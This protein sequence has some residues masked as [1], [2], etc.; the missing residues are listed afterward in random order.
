MGRRKIIR[1]PEEIVENE[2]T[3]KQR[4]AEYQK[5]Y[6]ERKKE[7]K[8]NAKTKEKTA[9]DIQPSNLSVFETSVVS[10]IC[11]ASTS[12]NVNNLIPSKSISPTVIKH[13]YSAPSIMK[14]GITSCTLKNSTTLQNVK[15]KQSQS[16]ASSINTENEHSNSCLSVSSQTNSQITSNNAH[17]VRFASLDRQNYFDTNLNPSTSR[18]VSQNLTTIVS[19]SNTNNL[20]EPREILDSREINWSKKQSRKARKKNFINVTDYEHLQ[21]NHIGEMDVICEHCGAKHFRAEITDKENSFNDCCAHGK[22]KLDNLPPL[23]NELN[24]LFSGNHQKS[25]EFFT[26]I[27]SYNNTLSFASFNANLVDLRS[28]RR[29]PYCFKIQGQIYY[30]VNTSLYSAAN[31]SPSYGQLFILDNNEATDCRLK[32]NSNLDKELLQKLD[33]IIRHNNVFAQSYLMMHEVVKEQQEQLN[34]DLPNLQMG[35][36]NNKT[37]LNRRRYNVQRTNE[38]AAVFATTAD[39]DIP[40][41]YVTIKNKRDKS[42]KNISNLNENVEPWIYPLYHP[43]GTPGWNNNIPQQENTSKTVTRLQYTSYRIAIRENENNFILKGRKLFQQWVVDSYVKIEKERI[44][45]CKFNQKKLRVESYTGLMEH[46]QNNANNMNVNLGR[47]TVLPSSFIGSPRNMMQKYQDAMAIVRKYGK[48]DLFITMTCNPNWPEIKEN[49]LPGQQPADRPD[50]CA[51]V[52]DIKKDSLIDLIVRQKF[53]GDVKAHVHV[54]EF[55]KRGLP[56]MHMLVTLKQNC[57]INNPTLV[58]KYI[59]AEIPD[60]QTNK[61]LHEI[62][63]KNMIHGPCGSWCMENGKCSKHYPKPFQPETTMD[64]NGYPQYRRRDTGKSFTKLNNFTFDNRHVVPY[65]PEFLEIYNCHINVEIVT[66]IKSVKYLYKYIYKGHDAASVVIGEF[67]S[68]RE[69]THDEIKAF[70]EARYVGPVEACWRIQSKPLQ[71]KSH[72]VTRLPVHLPNGQ[73]VVIPDGSNEGDL[74]SALEKITMLLDYFDLNERDI[75][76][77]K[78]L[79][80]DIPM[81]YVFKK[82]KI[83]G[84][85]VY[86]WEK[87]QGLFNTIGRMYAIS[88]NQVELFH[89][90]ILLLNVKGSKSFTD[91]RTVNGEVYQTYTETC[92]R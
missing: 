37:G 66:N 20:N 53:F 43:F 21:E 8:R 54:I 32:Q 29:G 45:F 85:V 88:P 7:E 5:N 11:T 56:H 87:R 70:V 14:R 63:M 42:L 46:L 3:K 19:N 79:Y 13:V 39:G 92:L 59:S 49:L 90:R 83:D 26:N 22:V 47:I 1:T 16:I 41:M 17:G 76:A 58:D 80:S 44:D 18:S 15:E 78:Y 34:T 36:L 2:V 84:K 69:L 91:L 57:K 72:F 25:H 67:T 24:S 52:F 27:R 74:R 61:H 35:F 81:H 28:Q 89:I 64:E 55:Q 75:D 71:N 40:N 60:P 30:R 73:N 62:V 38:V 23:P 50:I 82:V 86:R 51:R 31:E 77:R 10:N 33:L 9:N 68:E 12:K 48:P 6:R 4:A 65:C